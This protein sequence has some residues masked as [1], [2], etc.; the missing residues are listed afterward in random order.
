METQR[1]TKMEMRSRATRRV[2]VLAA[3]DLFCS[4][5]FRE[6]TMESIAEAADVSVQTVYF[7]FKTK[8]KLLQAVHEWTVLGDDRLAP[9]EQPWFIEAVAEQDARDALARIV[10][11]VAELDARMAPM[12]PIFNAL[13]QGSGGEIYRGSN[14]L[15]RK[16]MSELA[17]LLAA[18]TPFRPGITPGFAADLLF[19]LTGPESYAQLVIQTGWSRERWVEWVSATLVGQLFPSD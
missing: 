7:Q 4:R 18:K 14:E 19:F 16:G 2:V 9:A 17:A 13:A 8:A 3:Y 1:A 11:G 15:R 10:A 12:L 5:G 6:T